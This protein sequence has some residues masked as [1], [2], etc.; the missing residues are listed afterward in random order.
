M[1]N[2]PKLQKTETGIQKLLDDIRMNTNE[3]QGE[4]FNS[5]LKSVGINKFDG[6]QREFF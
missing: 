1:K 5:R 6:M 3:F 4:N 2:K